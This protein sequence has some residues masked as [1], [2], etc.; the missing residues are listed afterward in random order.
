[1]KT[2]DRSET[3]TNPI[4]RAALIIVIVLGFT[5]CGGESPIPGEAGGSCVFD[6]CNSGGSCLEAV[7]IAD[8]S[9]ALRQRCNID[10]QCNSQN[11]ANSRCRELD[12]WCS[13]RPQPC[14]KSAVEYC[15]RVGTCWFEISDGPAYDDLADV[16]AYCEKPQ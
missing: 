6:Q 16:V 9:R 3:P 10:R 14:N 13:D 11:C 2:E 12:T 1:M 5:A 4:L 7:C 8:S 15:C